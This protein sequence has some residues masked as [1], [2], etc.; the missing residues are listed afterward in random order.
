[1]NRTMWKNIFGEIR[2]TMGR[3]IAIFAIVALGAGFYAGIQATTPDMR[4]SADKYF[5]EYDL[6]DARI[7]S[8]LGFSQS[9]VDSFK[10]M[11]GVERVWA[12]YGL[13]V[14]VEAEDSSLKTVRLH[15]YTDDCMNKPQITQGRLPE[16]ANE[17]V[18]DGELT[19]YGWNIGDTMIISAQNDA[20]SY[21]MLVSKGYTIVGIANSPYYITFQRGKTNVGDGTIRGFV[22]IMEQ[23]FDSDAYLEVY[24]TFKGAKE[25]NTFSTKYN[26][27]SEEM[28]NQ[29]DAVAPEREQAR[30]D[31]I[32]GEAQQK[33]DDAQTELDDAKAEFE[34]SKQDAEAQL[35]DA[36]QKLDDGEK[37]IEDAE[38]TLR[39]SRVQLLAAQ[40][41]LSA[42]REEFV[43]QSAAGEK[44]INEAREELSAAD[45]QLRAAIA[46]YEDGM[47]QLEQLE[48]QIAELDS[49]GQS[50]QA[51]LLRPQA[52]ALSA[53]LSAA[54]ADIDSSSAQLNA[55]YIELNNNIE[56]LEA[57]KASAEEE[58]N[59]A[60]LQIDSGWAQYYSGRR[61]IADARAEL[62]EGKA[63]Y[64]QK[65]QEADEKLSQ[66]QAQL[67]DAQTQLEDAED[68][69]SD[70]Q[71]AT[72]YI[73]T[74]SDM[75]GYSSFEDTMKRVAALAD[76]FPVLFFIVAAL[77]C[78]TS[79]T[80]MVEEQRTQT[81]LLKALGYSKLSIAL[82][83]IFYAGVACIT[84]S[85]L[86][87][88]IGLR[89]FPAVIWSAY[90]I[91]YTLP[92]LIISFNI[93]YAVL[94]GTA[95]FA[96]TT[97]AT[98][99]A[100]YHDLKSVPADL[101]RPRAPLPGK[102]VFMERIPVIWNRLSFLT[103]VT[104]RNILRYKKRF[105]MTVIGI[106]GCTGLLLTGFGIRDSIT[107]IVDKQFGQLF[108]YDM[109]VVLSDPNEQADSAV[110]ALA[111]SMFY[112]IQDDAAIVS[113]TYDKNIT[114]F[115]PDN[116]DSM[117][118]LITLRDRGSQKMLE[119]PGNGSVVITERF[120]NQNGIQAGDTVT[121][122]DGDG[123]KAQFTVSGIC[124]N[125]VFSYVYMSPQDYEAAFGKHDFKM[126]FVAFGSEPTQEQKD[127]TAKE[128]LTYNKVAQVAF[129]S[130]MRAE[131]DNSIDGINV[132]VYV[133]ILCA[134]LLAFVVLYNLTNINITE[135]MREIATIKV[136][137]FYDMEVAGYVYRENMALT[138]IGAVIGLG[139]G[140]LMHR[141]VITTVEVDM[142]MFERL[143]KPISFVW[144]FLF[145]FGFSMFVNLVMFFKLKRISMVE[146]LKSV[147]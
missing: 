111:K 61:K 16:A 101:I 137:G 118:Q 82:K 33:I 63:E 55:G 136:L 106:A 51:D 56:Q 44:E 59:S 76:V 72:W 121:V 105:F 112:A 22:Y 109:M 69:L 21:D 116:M 92:E 108:N 91:L 73:Q 12:T 138:V 95:A 8:T 20:E 128:L 145:T 93:G 94:A 54:K 102:R 143:I 146:S 4:E 68:K 46:Q 71:D 9:D 2:A 132:V 35:A 123:T 139:L 65:K 19:K 122:R 37:D 85:A 100:C 115:V 87:I 18:I 62:E 84:G 86:G 52:Q 34:T 39:A 7:V 57:G 77:V 141:Y 6:M 49:T 90:A 43:L 79:M 66:A 58:F 36:K 3:F 26:N 60:Q 45:A 40:E 13:D 48:S 11:D 129:V 53:Q 64:E 78:L 135:R 81:G 17:C 99:W 110:R 131:F 41:A 14:L 15:A 103:K 114:L 130:D 88:M 144:S 29:L 98:I 107:G 120:A 24:L 127:Q 89:L 117:K 50:E 38:R 67:D 10:S 28:S 134:S 74:R 25:L 113:D 142:V 70:I 126:A 140:V 47:A 83:Y 42:E 125:Y 31:E 5:D 147:E 119:Y 23:N 133:I 27:I 97:G 80:R 75:S 124:E 96:C 30:K 1:M 32:I 104:V